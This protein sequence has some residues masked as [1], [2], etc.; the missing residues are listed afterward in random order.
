MKGMRI[1]EQEKRKFEALEEEFNSL[2]N[3]LSEEKKNIEKKFSPEAEKK[4]DSIKSQIKK[5]KY[6]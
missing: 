4:I 1:V 6:V 3:Q 2:H 5:L